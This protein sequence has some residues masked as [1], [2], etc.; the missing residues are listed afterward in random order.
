MAASSGKSEKQA[1]LALSCCCSCWSPA[2]SAHMDPT[3]QGLPSVSQDPLSMASGYLHPCSLGVGKE[4]PLF[5]PP[6]RL[7]KPDPAAG[8]VKTTGVP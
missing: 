6:G 3:S 7:Q 8:L 5:S 4:Q 2:G 1:P